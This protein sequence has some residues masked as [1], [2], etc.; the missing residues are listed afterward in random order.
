MSCDQVVVIDV[1]SHDGRYIICGSED[2]SVYI[3]RTQHEFYK[4]SSAR[5]DRND[6]WENVKGWTVFGFCIP[7]YIGFSDI[8]ASIVTIR[9]PFL[10]YN[11]I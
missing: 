8:I 6:Y 4:F 9:S 3:W 1:N 11:T 2:Q 7:L 10:G 5:R